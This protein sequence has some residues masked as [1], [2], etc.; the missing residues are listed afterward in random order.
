MHSLALN[1]P[2]ARDLAWACFS[3]P[4]LHLT[5]PHPTFTLTPERQQW[6]KNLDKDPTP[7][8][9]FLGRRSEGRLGL[10]FEALWRFFLHADPLCELIAHNLPVRSLGRTLGEFDLIYFCRE[11]NRFCHLELALKFYLGT[12]AADASSD[13]AWAAWVGPNSRDRLDLKLEK[14]LSKQSQLGLSLAGQDALAALGVKDAL[15]EI[16]VAGRLYRHPDA[17]CALPA[18]YNND[19]SAQVW[20]HASGLSQL[21]ASDP[22]LSWHPLKRRQ[23]LAPVGTQETLDPPLTGTEAL[24]L[25]I[26]LVA[27]RGGAEYA[28]CFVV[29]DTWPSATGVPD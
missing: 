27:L 26:Q 24:R 1:T 10:Y 22:A 18:E 21:I 4:L 14:L 3:P 23:W 9:D 13:Q 12:E 19:L 15:P 6:L 28:R 29:A 5:V 8:L 16:R 20:R 25:P 17:A 7:L 2:I 11:R